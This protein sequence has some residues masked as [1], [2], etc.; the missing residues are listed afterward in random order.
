MN[1]LRKNYEKAKTKYDNLFAKSI[2]EIWTEEL[3]ELLCE[4]HKIN[5]FTV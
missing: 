1:K 3:D 5:A 2:N 4:Y